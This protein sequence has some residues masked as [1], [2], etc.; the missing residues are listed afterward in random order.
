VFRTRAGPPELMHI[1]TMLLA[2]ESEP[3]LAIVNTTLREGGSDCYWIE[4]Q[5]SRR[6]LALGAG[7][8]LAV[9]ASF[10]DNLNF[11]HAESVRDR[12]SDELHTSL[13]GAT[14][15]SGANLCVTNVTY[16]G[17]WGATNLS[18][19]NFPSYFLLTFCLRSAYFLTAR[20]CR[21]QLPALG[22]VAFRPGI[23]P[24]R[25]ALCKDEPRL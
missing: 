8:N 23:S 1:S 16:G 18:G 20:R 6:A 7:A 24:A 14:N 10:A 21:C 17:V 9:A 22:L 2:F 25:A 5:I 13:W 11:A 15:L 12:C 19:A 3:M 4:R